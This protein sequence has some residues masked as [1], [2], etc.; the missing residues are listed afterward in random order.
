[1]LKALF[2][3]YESIKSCVR[4]KTNVQAFFT[5]HTRVKQGDPLLPVL[6]IFFINDLL[7]ST[8]SNKIDLFDS[9]YINLFMLIYA[10][11][12][13]FFQNHLFTCKTC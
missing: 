12:A 10:D 4:Y 7:E 6:F 5:I 9:N 8:C 3:I 11:D 13:Y 2:S 1:M